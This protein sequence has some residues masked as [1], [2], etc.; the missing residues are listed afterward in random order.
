MLG[1]YANNVPFLGHHFGLEPR[2]ALSQELAKLFCKRLVRWNVQ[3]AFETASGDRT[4]APSE[5]V[6]KKWGHKKEK[7]PVPG[8]VS[9]T[10]L[11]AAI[12]C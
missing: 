9:R 2:P 1:R 8:A 5:M 6:E 12:W 7:V 11:S 10:G 3:P 4:Q